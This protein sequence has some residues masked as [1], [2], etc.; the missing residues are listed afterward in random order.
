[1][2]KTNKEN[3]G[4]HKKIKVR[5]GFLLPEMQRALF[6]LQVERKV[7]TLYRMS[8][9]RAFLLELCSAGIAVSV[10]YVLIVF[11]APAIL[12]LPICASVAWYVTGVFIA[13]YKANKEKEC[14]ENETK[15]IR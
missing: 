7:R 10:A 1:L 15:G 11:G 9:T 14:V 13:K 3:A 6:S 8:K 5:K 2:R 12:V 4:T